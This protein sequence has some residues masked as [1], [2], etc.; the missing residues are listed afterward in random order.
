MSVNSYKSLFNF[1][2]EPVFTV[3]LLR[4]TSLKHAQKETYQ[5]TENPGKPERQKC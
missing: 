5:V 1:L 4:G 2:K 3:T